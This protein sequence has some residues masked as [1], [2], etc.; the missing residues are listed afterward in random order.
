M[1]ATVASVADSGELKPDRDGFVVLQAGDEQWQQIPGLDGVS[2]MKVFSDSSQPGVYVVRVRFQPW[3]MTMPHVHSTER[4][5]VV[6]KGTWYA[7]T[8]TQFDPANTTPIRA[9]GYMLHPANGV[10]FDGAKDEEV[11]LQITGSGP[12]KTTFLDPGGER[13]RSLK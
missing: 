12:M 6:V 3:T 9:G 4:L 8:D 7:G 2:Y 13:A 10:H 11:V 5:V 1:S